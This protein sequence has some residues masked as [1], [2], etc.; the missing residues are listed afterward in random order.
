M[1]AF[2]AFRG[3]KEHSHLPVNCIQFGT[4][5]EGHELA[6]QMYV[7]TKH[8][9]DKSFKLS[10]SKGRKRDTKRA[11]RLPVYEDDLSCPGG[12]IYCYS[13]TLAPNQ[14]R[15]YC[16]DASMTQEKM[17]AKTGLTLARWNPN[18]PFGSNEIGKLMKAGCK[19]IGLK[20][21]GH[22][23]RALA[24]TTTVNGKMNP[25]ESIAFSRHNSEAAQSNYQR[26][27]N[28]SEMAKFNALGVARKR[29]RP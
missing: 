4:F 16:H 12:T 26:Q 29:K 25:K 23:L 27:N 22:G 20:C 24:I 9:L 6:G 14:K 15:W 3:N 2:L 8:L 7:E 19:K 11:M 28:T 5:E 18:K 1:G 21:T 13:K 10:L 17:Y